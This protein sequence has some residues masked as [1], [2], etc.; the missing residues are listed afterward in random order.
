MV[1]FIHKL[2][3]AKE[4]QSEKLPIS[5]EQAHC[6]PHERVV[7]MRFLYRLEKS[8]AYFFG[9]VGFVSVVIGGAHAVARDR[10]H[11]AHSSPGGRAGDG[12]G[13]AVERSVSKNASVPWRDVFGPCLVRA[14]G[15]SELEK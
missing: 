13:K 2:W 8:S 5:E 6:L 14:E 15:V 9:S 10:V 7:P 11:A 1:I 12:G 4:A 3:A